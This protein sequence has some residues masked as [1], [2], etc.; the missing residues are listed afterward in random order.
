MSELNKEALVEWL[1]QNKAYVWTT[2]SKFFPKIT[3]K[4][5]LGVVNKEMVIDPSTTAD[6]LLSAKEK[7]KQ[8]KEAWKNILLVLDKEAFRDDVEALCTEANVSFLNNKVPSWLFTNF[9]TFSKSIGAMNSLRKLISSDKF[10]KLTKKEQ[11]I[12]KRNLSKLE[13]VYKGVTNLKKIPDLVI[14]VDAEYNT[15]VIKELEKAKI[16]YIAI[17]NTDLSRWLSTEN[18][19]V[20]NTNSYESIIYMLNYLLK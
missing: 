3:E 14:V 8:T 1:V 4:S 11:L 9:S 5:T 15:W 16:N 20:A 12:H 17:A 7:I 13:V 18:L 19:I 10:S 2:R 6:E